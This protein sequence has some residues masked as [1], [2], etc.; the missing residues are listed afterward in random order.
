MD[1]WDY[2]GWT[3]RFGQAEFTKRQ[4]MLASLNRSRTIYTPQ[5]V[6][7]GRDFRVHSQFKD[8]VA[9][10]NRTQPRADIDLQVTPQTGSLD[11]VA[12][13][14]I[15]KEMARLPAVMYVA[16][17]EDNLKSDVTA[18]ENAG[19][20]LHHQFVVRRWIGPVSP[21]PEGQVHWEQQLSIESGWK[22]QDMGVVVCVI[23]LRS[24]EV[25]QA[26]ALPLDRKAKDR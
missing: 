13:A 5:L 12:K 15:S 23:N 26:V 21:T 14:S 8:Q 9:R 17:Y 16:L 3:D 24:G 1:Y 2:L 7:Q 10:I 20:T 4:R 19:R 6:L 22:P 25:L 11:V 18:G